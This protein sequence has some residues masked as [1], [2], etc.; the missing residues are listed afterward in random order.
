M[1]NRVLFIF[2]TRPEAIK[3]APVIAR[4]RERPQ[5]FEVRVTVTGQHRGM[6]DSVLDV[7]GIVPDNNLDIMRPGQPLAALTARALEGLDDVIGREQPA[8]VVVQGDTATT[9]A[10]ALAAY[11][12][13][14]PVAHVEAGLRTGDRYQPFPEEMN[15]R[16]T[17]HLA[18]WHFAP[19]DAAR[20]HLLAEGVDATRVHVTGNTV[21]DALLEIAATPWNF[22]PGPIADAVAAGRAG[23]ERLLLVTTHRREN[24][25]APLDEVAAALA[26]LLRRFPD[27]RVLYACHSNP[28]ARAAAERALGTHPRVLL[29]EP[30]P[31]LQFVKLMQAA[32][33]IV[34]D[35]GGI[36]EEAPSLGKPVLVLRNVTERPEAVTAGAARV[37]GTR[38][39][40]IVAAAATL[41]ADPTAYAAMARTA[42]PFGDGRAAE[43]IAAVLAADIGSRPA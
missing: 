21:I 5:D 27:I 8:A 3:L 30:V 19:T 25:G 40:D 23:N 38:T 43:R 10:G 1:A 36:Q 41:L 39:A 7:F 14:V 24:L 29:L 15:R 32:T 28:L 34:T 11:W 16:L 12:H 13:R 6:L 42:N 26:E 35:S 37:T 22:P 33:L 20:G 18:T 9:L 31:Y 17:T 4:L 2:G